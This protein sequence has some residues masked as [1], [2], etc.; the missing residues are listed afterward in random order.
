[1]SLNREEIQ[2]R[3]QAFVHDQIEEELSKRAFSND[4][5]DLILGTIKRSNKLISLIQFIKSIG[6]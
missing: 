2:Q 5:L 3:H 1:M 4:E 6:K